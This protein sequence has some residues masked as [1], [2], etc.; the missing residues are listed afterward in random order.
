MLI[1][2]VAFEINGDKHWSFMLPIY[3]SGWNYFIGHLKF[4]TFTILP[5][6]RYW[7]KPE[8]E[9]FFFGVHGGF[10]YYNVA[11]NGEKRYQDHDKT[12]PALGGGIN[13]GYRLDISQN[14]RWKLEF[15]LGCGVYHLDYDKF[16][17]RVDGLR[18]ER[19]K[20]TF[21]GIDNFA[22]SIAYQFDIR[23]NRK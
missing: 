8:N 9:G 19:E 15:S 7:L 11:F 23:R 17:N 2:N 10:A 20:R 16:I 6:V 1:S 5:E 14:K 22:V 12:T 18:I 4:R 3:Y 21:F 13:A